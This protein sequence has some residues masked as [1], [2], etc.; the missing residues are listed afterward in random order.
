MKNSVRILI[1]ITM[2]AITSCQPEVNDSAEIEKNVKKVASNFRSESDIVVAAGTE[3]YMGQFNHEA[4][5]VEIFKAIYDGKVQAYDFLDNPLSL[6]E[7]K[8]IESHIDTA[9]VEDIETGFIDTVLIE[10]RLNPDD[11]VKIFTAEDWY[12]NTENFSLEKKV[13]SVTLTTLKLNLEGDPIGYD[14]LFKV[15]FDGRDQLQ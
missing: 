1:A 5:V 8:Y 7:V 3:H 9:E 12:I 4:F 11:V 15:Y 14:I 10:E 13:I 6:E 2:L